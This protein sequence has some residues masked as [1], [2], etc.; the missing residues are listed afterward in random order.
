[1]KGACLL[2][3]LSLAP[4]AAQNGSQQPLTITISA[5]TPSVK[6][7]SDVWVIVKITNHTTERLDESEIISGMTSFDPKLVFEVR[8]TGGNL[9]GKV[10]E[11]PKRAAELKL[12]RSIL[13]GATLTQQQNLSR[14][15]DVSHPGSYVVQVSRSPSPGSTTEV[16]KSNNL[17]IEVKAPT[18]KSRELSQSGLPNPGGAGR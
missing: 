8:D 11:H 14:F 6:A 3:L 7:G 4:I 9:M 15:Y 10:Y 2:L 16:V 13:S 18:L 5:L 12:D 1:M 17:T